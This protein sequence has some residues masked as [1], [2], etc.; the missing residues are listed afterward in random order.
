MEGNSNDFVIRNVHLPYDDADAAS[1]LYNVHCADGI[2]RTIERAGTSQSSPV[3][4]PPS[5]TTAEVDARGRGILLPADF[6]EALRVTAKAKQNFPSNPDDLYERGKKLITQSIECGVTTMRAHVEVDST[7][8]FACLDTGLRLKTEFEPLCSI[9]LAGE[10]PPRLT[11]SPSPIPPHSIRARPAIPLPASEHPDQTTS[12]CA[13]PRKGPASQPWD[14]RH[15]HLD[16]TLDPAAEPLIWTVLAQLRAHVHAGRWRTGARVCIGHATRLTLFTQAMGLPPSDMYMMA[17]TLDVPRLAREH[18]LRVA[19]AVNNVGNAF[20][21]HGPVD[22]LALC[23]LGVALFRAG[24]KADC[25]SLLEAITVNA[26]LA[27]G[28]ARD[29]ERGLVPAPGDPADFVLLHDNDSLHSA[30]LSPSFTR[31]TIRR[32]AL[33]SRRSEQKWMRHATT[34]I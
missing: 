3:L 30:A 34:T 13:P 16:Y 28:E 18:G 9:Q 24:T 22:P 4:E 23:P 8:H 7:V 10:S 27:I 1:Q 26:R 11:H 17:G 14:R 6:S 19:M 25:R 5:D 32:G 12:S 20:T 21:P 15:F 31:S 2:V 33:V 29:G